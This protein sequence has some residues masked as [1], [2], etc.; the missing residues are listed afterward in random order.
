MHAL[1]W[2]KWLQEAVDWMD[3]RYD[4]IK[5]TNDDSWEHDA[6]HAWSAGRDPGEFCDEFVRSLNEWRTA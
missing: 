2:D 5:L 6:W 3:C 1:S 4:L